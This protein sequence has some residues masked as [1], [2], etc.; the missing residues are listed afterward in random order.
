MTDKFLGTV[1]VGLTLAA[2]GGDPGS[3]PGPSGPVSSEVAA[4]LRFLREEEKLAR[5]V[6]TTLYDSW[7][8]M[9]HHNIANS[10][11]THFNRV[12][13]LLVALDLPDP[14]VN[15]TVGAFANRQLAGLYVDL[16]AKG[17]RSEVAA[18]EVGATIEELDI[19][20]LDRMAART[21][22]AGVLATYAVLRCGSGN[23]LRAFTAELGSRGASY[24]PLY[25]SEA[26]YNAVI[27]SK[28]ESCRR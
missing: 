9:Q 23:H 4:D 10:E 25:L 3:L 14:V 17:Q 26:D 6:Y 11:Q 12:E 27:A 22:D 5:D 15:D 18:L 8:L 1:L 20:D 2:C 19:H 21:T 28:R 7:R 13:D 24:A 16:V